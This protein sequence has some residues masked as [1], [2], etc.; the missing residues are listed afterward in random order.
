MHAHVHRC[1]NLRQRALIRVARRYCLWWASAQ[2][3]RWQCH[4]ISLNCKA[5]KLGYNFHLPLNA[6]IN[7]K[8][9]GRHKKRPKYWGMSN[10]V[11]SLFFCWQS[12]FITDYIHTLYR[13]KMVS[14]PYNHPLTTFIYIIQRGRLNLAAI[15]PW[16]ADCLDPF[17]AYCWLILHWHYT[18]INQ[19]TIF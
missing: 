6:S 7:Q 3:E 10:I 13:S 5:L 15:F 9:G 11:T 12:E 17:L 18:I 8:R 4:F 14:F 19:K 16:D 2:W 1:S